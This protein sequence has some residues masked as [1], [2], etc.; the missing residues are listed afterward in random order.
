MRTSLSLLILLRILIRQ[1]SIVDIGGI[2]ESYT[3]TRTLYAFALE[4][5]DDCVNKDRR[6]YRGIREIILSNMS[7]LSKSFFQ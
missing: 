4:F 7:F 5:S 3:I 1:D 2:I 6:I